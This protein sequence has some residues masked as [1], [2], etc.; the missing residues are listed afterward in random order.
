MYAVTYQIDFSNVPKALNI[1]HEKWKKKI[2][3]KMFSS[4]CSPLDIS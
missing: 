1:S 4:H 3:H 2:L